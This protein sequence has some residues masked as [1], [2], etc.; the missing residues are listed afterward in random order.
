[1]TSTIT[2]VHLFSP[3][4]SVTK[5]EEFDVDFARQLADD[6]NIPKEER[7]KIRRYVK[8]RSG[9]NKHE[10][11]YKLGKN[12]KHEFLGRLCALKSDSLQCLGKD[13]RNAIASEF[14]WDLDFVNA[15]PTLLQQYAKKNG[16]KCDS[17]N[18]YVEHREEYLTEICEIMNVD[19]WEAKEKVVSIL[20]GCGASAVEGMPSFFVHEFYS[21][22]RLI[23]KNNFEANKAVLKWLEKQPNC[24]G[25]GLA[26]VLQTE[27][28]NCL[29]ALDRA[30]QRKGRS[31]D[32]YI[33]DGGLVRKKMGEVVFPTLLLRE[34]ESEVENET[35][36]VLR[37][38][39]KSMKT[40]FTK[41][42]TEDDYAEVK[43]EFE[44]MHFKLRNPPR[45]VCQQGSSFTYL[46]DA[47]LNFNYRNKFLSSGETFVSRWI[48]DPDIR[49]YTQFEFKPKMETTKGC[50][51]LFQGFPLEPK[52]GDW[53]P[54]R[55]LLWDLSGRN[56]DNFDY[57]MNWSA[58]LFQKP[59]EKPEVFV[60][61]SSLLE[62]V[63]KDTYADHVLRPMLGNDYYFTTTDH[64]NE[65]FGRFNSHL[66]N[67]LLIK[68]EEM[69]YEVMIRND[70]K[71][72]GWVTTHSKSYEEKGVTKSPPIQSFLRLMGST[73]EACPLKLTKSFRRYFLVNPFQGN[74]GNTGYWEG[75]Y[76]ELKKPEVL[77]AFYDHLLSIDIEN[78]NPR[79]KCE[80]NALKEAR[81]SQA[82]PHARFFQQHIQM[83]DENEVLSISAYDLL[84]QVNGV[85]KFPYTPFK[86]ASVLKE[87][88]HTK[89][90]K[91]TGNT[92][93][94]VLAD[95]RDYLEKA[96]FW[97]DE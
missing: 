11:T 37:L 15:Q 56:Q 5:T 29:L 59:F 54:V 6:K 21:E 50:F 38:A 93:D 58:H 25:K 90:H 86:L 26:Y 61:F 44:L 52:K 74:A 14:Y 75:M 33:H 46:T 4:W 64:E 7:E 2:D 65:F 89:I 13:I 70:D 87:F 78:W 67:K 81:Q 60:I 35:G 62:G 85:S 68:L 16:W 10:T 19:R 63:G 72:K 57:L 47:E 80:T 53:T 55:E 12:C 48:L 97:V 49:T 30:I 88:P 83:N 43:A 9:G 39:V 91:K 41:V 28:R 3:D 77:Q 76:K 73:N 1:M 96:N 42:S 27:E 94:F 45:Y 95:V 69:N 22:L 71:L 23:M 20:F 51:N 84:Q 31:M 36:Y 34:L 17:L 24:V 66:Q 40:T 18:A 8:N 92:Y 32:C 79:T 82:P